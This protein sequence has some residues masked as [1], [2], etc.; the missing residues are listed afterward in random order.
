[1]DVLF[2]IQGL[3]ESERILVI[4]FEYNLRWIYSRHYLKDVFDFISGHPYKIG[5]I[6]SETI[7]VYERWHPEL[8]KF[9]EGNYLL[10]HQKSLK[11]F[12]LMEGSFDEYNTYGC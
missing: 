8:E 7:E 2:G 9:F 1:M 6:T 12:D 3:I 10:I 4:Q 11:W 5:K